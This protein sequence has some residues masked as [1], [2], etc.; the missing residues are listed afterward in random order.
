MNSHRTDCAEVRKEKYWIISWWI[1]AL[2]QFIPAVKS[3]K[4]NDQ[5]KL[6]WEPENINMIYFIHRI[7]GKENE[8]GSHTT[9]LN[10]FYRE[11]YRCWDGEKVIPELFLSLQPTSGNFLWLHSNM[12]Q[13]VLF[14]APSFLSIC[15]PLVVHKCLGRIKSD[16]NISNSTA[17]VKF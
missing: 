10:S 5:P 2:G 8:G 3:R 16:D 12:H 1:T 6:S 4:I 9:F 15:W 14:R 11:D 17:S 7:L 13:C